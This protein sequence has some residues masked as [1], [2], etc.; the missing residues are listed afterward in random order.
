MV[1]TSNLKKTKKAAIDQK[2]GYWL[3][4][5]TLPRSPHTWTA[6]R[7]DSTSI[8]EPCS[9]RGLFE[10]QDLFGI[11]KDLLGLETFIQW[12]LCGWL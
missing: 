10:S 11:P 12:P 9:N 6:D 2:K 1:V 8:I 3:K 5:F 7:M 4:A